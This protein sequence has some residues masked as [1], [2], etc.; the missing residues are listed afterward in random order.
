MLPPFI[1]VIMRIDKIEHAFYNKISLDTLV[2][3]I[4]NCHKLV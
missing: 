2:V 3:P 1:L 4:A